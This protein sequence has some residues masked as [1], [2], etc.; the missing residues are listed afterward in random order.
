MLGPQVF[1]AYF[2]PFSLP[3]DG[4]F[5]GYQHQIDVADGTDVNLSLIDLFVLKTC[6]KKTIWMLLDPQIIIDHENNIVW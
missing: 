6:R 1:Y 3:I 4:F 2:R 5:P